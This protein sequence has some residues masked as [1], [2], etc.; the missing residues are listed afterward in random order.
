MQTLR[1]RQLVEKQQ[2]EAQR[3][4]QVRPPNAVNLSAHAAPLIQQASRHEQLMAKMQEHLDKLSSQLELER[5]A[6]ERERERVQQLEA[7]FQNE[8]VNNTNH[9]KEERRK[10]QLADAWLCTGVAGA[11]ACAS[12]CGAG[13]RN[14]EQAGDD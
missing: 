14:A 12:H 2:A 4:E 1:E 6:A 9:K 13:A 8:Q 10:R 5:D 3:Q 11:G 7:Q